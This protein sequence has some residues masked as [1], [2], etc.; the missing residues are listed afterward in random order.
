[1]SDTNLRDLYQEV[2]L[3]HNKNPRNFH[4]MDDAT[5][6][7]EGNNPLCGD[8]IDVYVKVSPE[9]IVEDVSFQGSGCAI[10]KSSASLMT[11]LVKGKSVA[12]ADELFKTFHDVVMS[13][14]AT[15]IT[16]E[17][18]DELG[19]LGVFAGVRDYPAR[20]KCASL[21]WHTVHAALT[22]EAEAVSTE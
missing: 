15:E 6:H 9:G 10:S 19:K 1:M 22:K 8:Q 7:A 20:V 11:T 12:D 17:K 4:T 5:N 21:A 16:D 18:L 2:I 13:G 14:P 3:D